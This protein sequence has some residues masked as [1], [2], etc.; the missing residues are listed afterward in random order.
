MSTADTIW[1]MP[2]CGISQTL[3]ITTYSN[4]FLWDLHPFFYK[5]GFAPPLCGLESP[6]TD[7][8]PPGIDQITNNKINVYCNQ[9]YVFSGTFK[10]WG[11][12]V[13]NG[14]NGLLNN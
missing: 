9:T 11:G 8:Y 7:T 14:S 2:R 10:I 6:D 12:N 1:E 3:V 5:K 4:F 13:V